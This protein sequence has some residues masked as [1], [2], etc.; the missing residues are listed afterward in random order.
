MAIMVE[1]IVDAVKEVG[2]GVAVEGVAVEILWS[3]LTTQIHYGDFK[4]LHD[5]LY[6]VSLGD[7]LP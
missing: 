6:A 1:V 5:A 7:G 4:E 3:F 2:G